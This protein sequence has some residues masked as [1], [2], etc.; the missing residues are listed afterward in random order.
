MFILYFINI[1]S[2]PFRISKNWREDCF[3]II[4]I[5]MSEA[6]YYQLHHIMLSLAKKLLFRFFKRNDYILILYLP[7]LPNSSTPRAANMKNSKKNSRPKFPTCGKACIT[8]SSKDRIP[9]AIFRSFKT[10][11][12]EINNGTVTM[13]RIIYWWS[14]IVEA[15]SGDILCIFIL[16]F[17]DRLRGGLFNPSMVLDL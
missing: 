6:N 13:I 1:W 9:F 4:C 10:E 7:S 8:V 17:Q 12:I 3:G 5:V 15:G 11:K 2:V 14:F 16:E